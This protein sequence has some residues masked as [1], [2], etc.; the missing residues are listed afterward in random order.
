MYLA[1]EPFGQFQYSTVQYVVKL[2]AQI[3]FVLLPEVAYCCLLLGVSRFHVTLYKHNPRFLSSAIVV[4]DS[5][6][7]PRSRIL[8]AK[9]TVLQLV[10]IFAALYV[11]RRFI[12]AFTRAHHLSLF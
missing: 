10:K 5:L 7:P 1:L 12:T 2:S 3:T 6:L 8:L 9:L 11:T 4:A